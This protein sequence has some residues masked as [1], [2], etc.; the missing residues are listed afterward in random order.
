TTPA[1][2]NA[3]SATT[4]IAAT[5]TATTAA[6]TP[7]VTAVPANPTTGTV[8]VYSSPAGASILIDGIYIGTAP[9][10][11]NDVPSGNHILRLSLSGYHDY[12]GSIYVVP[13][14]TD[15]AFGSL[16]P[17]GQVTGAVPTQTAVVT[18]LVPVIAVTPEPSGNSNA[19][20]DSGV[21]AAIIG[22]IGVII[23]S[24]AKIFTHVRPP[25]K[26]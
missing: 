19:L 9:R 1:A 4:T 24:A 13:G 22:A 25:R 10:T 12:E 18:V 15:Q 8:I 26:E 11:I 5:P 3:T 23:L 21:I 7:P 20:G 17:V 16:Q 14:Q 2:T 6:A